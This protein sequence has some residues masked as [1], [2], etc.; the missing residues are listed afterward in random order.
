MNQSKIA[1]R[2]A[3]ALFLTAL[4]K[5][6]LEQ[7]HNDMQLIDSIL[8]Q[9]ENF[10]AFLS[11]PV[12]K[13]SAKIKFIHQIFANGLIQEITLNFLNL[14]V[15]NNRAIHI[16]AM[17]NYF[18]QLYRTQKGIKSAVFI[19]ATEPDEKLNKQLS[20]V[21]KDLYKAEIELQVTTDKDLVGGFI[22]RIEDQQYDASIAT[23]LK[24][25]KADLIKQ[26]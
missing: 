5:D 23:A 25:M 8:H 15:Q 19:T 13:P 7:V 10:K 12:N 16:P 9:I 4:E 3:K 24:K 6:I 2:Y 18:M 21:L 22:L 26:N 14:V 11:S 17:T 20:K 1:V